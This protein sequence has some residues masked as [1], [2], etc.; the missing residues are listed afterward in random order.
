MTY[1][2]FGGCD[3]VCAFDNQVIGE[4]QE[5]CY[6]EQANPTQQN[7]SLL[8]IEMILFSSTVQKL[9]FLK[10][11]TK[12]HSFTASYCNEYGDK[13][14]YEFPK[15]GYKNYK[16]KSSID[17]IATS[18]LLEYEVFEEPDILSMFTSSKPEEITALKENLLDYQPL[19]NT[20]YDYKLTIYVPKVCHSQDLIKENI[21]DYIISENIYKTAYYDNMDKLKDIYMQCILYNDYPCTIKKNGVVLFKGFVYELIKQQKDLELVKTKQEEFEE[22]NN[23]T[24]SVVIKASF[25]LSDTILD[26]IYC[27]DSSQLEEISNIYLSDFEFNMGANNVKFLFKQKWSRLQA[28]DNCPTTMKVLLCGEYIHCFNLCDIENHTA[29][30]LSNVYDIVDIK[31][32]SDEYIQLYNFEIEDITFIDGNKNKFKVHKRVIDEYNKKTG[33]VVDLY[34]SNTTTE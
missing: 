13:I 12:V 1:T 28:K 31:M 26:N 24:C 27:D 14:I 15:I 2:S 23:K 16:I 17:N 34:D 3:L 32:H 30:Y 33:G 21:D 22:D 10:D 19:R 5:Y 6:K 25:D 11:K 29:K 18:I 9:K 4:I 8:T 7:P 20:E